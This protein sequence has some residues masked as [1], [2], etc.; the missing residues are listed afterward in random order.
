MWCGGSKKDP[1]RLGDFAGPCWECSDE[2]LGVDVKKKVR[3]G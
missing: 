1:S 3:V 2:V